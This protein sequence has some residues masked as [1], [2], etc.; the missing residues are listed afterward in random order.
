MNPS[1]QF[2]GVGQKPDPYDGC[3]DYKYES[4]NGHDF[5]F[6]EESRRCTISDKIH[7]AQQANAKSLVISHNEDDL[8]TIQET[9]Q[10]PGVMIPIV[11]IQKS[12]FLVIK[13][14]LNS[15]N[16]D[17]L[18][19]KLEIIGSLREDLSFEFWYSPNQKKAIDFITDVYKNKQGKTLGLNVHFQPNFVLWHCE[20]CQDNGF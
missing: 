6:I 11:V 15:V 18:K 10:F 20:E 1:L 17:P 2:D 13:E 8:S 14:L 19:L 16:S 3:S 9:E 4:G 12:S 5:F 7:F